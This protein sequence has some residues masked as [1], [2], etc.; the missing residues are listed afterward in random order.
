MTFPDLDEEIM[1]ET[2]DDD[3][4]ECVSSSIM[5]PCGSWMVWGT[6]QTNSIAPVGFPIGCQEKTTCIC[7]TSSFLTITGTIFA[8]CYICRNECLLVE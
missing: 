8:Q 1:S 5:L 7:M 4:D 2:G 3:V 6:V